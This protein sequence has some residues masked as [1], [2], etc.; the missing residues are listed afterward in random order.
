MLLYRTT[1]PGGRHETW[2]NFSI[3][4][5]RRVTDDADWSASSVLW[6]CHVTTWF[7]QVCVMQFET[8][9]GRA[10]GLFL[11]SKILTDMWIAR[12]HLPIFHIR[13][14]PAPNFFQD[15]STTVMDSCWKYTKQWRNLSKTIFARTGPRF[16]DQDQGKSSRTT[17]MTQRLLTLFLLTSRLRLRLICNETHTHTTKNHHHTSHITLS[18]DNSECSSGCDSSFLTPN[19]SAKFRRGHRQQGAK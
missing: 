4:L 12:L 7:L 10:Q 16:Q 1:C 13:R 18:L 8:Q 2:D 19:I 3:H 17:T 11:S 6:H 9:D 15:E 5:L 14:F